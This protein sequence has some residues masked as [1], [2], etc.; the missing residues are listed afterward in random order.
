[1]WTFAS[2]GVGQGF[3]MAPSGALTRGDASVA[4]TLRVKI[5]HAE[6]EDFTPSAPLSSTERGWG[7]GDALGTRILLASECPLH[8]V[9]PALSSREREPEV[10]GGELAAGSRE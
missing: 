3:K 1:M 6:R 5:H 9:S 4:F 10:F 7:R 2:G 8:P